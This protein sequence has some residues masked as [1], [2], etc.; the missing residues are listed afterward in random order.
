VQDLDSVLAANGGPSLDDLLSDAD[1][2]ANQP[3]AVTGEQ[4]EPAVISMLDYYRDKQGNLTM[5]KSTRRNVY[6]ALRM[7][8]RWGKRVWEDQ[9]KGVLMLDKE[10]YKDTDDTRI[11]IWLDQVYEL[12]ASTTAV[13]DVTRLIGEENGINPLTEYLDAVS[14]D[15]QERISRWLIDGVG[16]E[17]TTLNRDLG[18]RWLVQAVAR[19]FNPGCKADCVLVLIGPQGVKK[20]TAFRKLAGDEYFADTPMEFGTPNAYSQIRRVWIYE[21]A[22]L[23]SVRRS[24]A[25][26][27]KAFL[28]AQDDTYRPAYGR[29][30]ITVKRHCVFCGTTN[31]QSF[32]NDST[33]SRRFWPVQV[34]AINVDWI[35]ENRDQ[36]WAEAVRAYKNGSRWWLEDGS[37]S[38]LEEASQRFQYRDPWEDHIREWLTRSPNEFTTKDL[39]AGALKLE[40]NHM[41]RGAEMRAAEILHIFGYQR[42]RKRVGN[43]RA[44]VWTT[45][46]DVIAIKPEEPTAIASND[47]VPW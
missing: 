11:A 20:S 25:S 27:T 37:E 28:S 15:S 8:T 6:T 1:D 30:S 31:G 14:W 40:P 10:D 9:F 33:G 5:P 3:N 26:A 16:A 34:G 7:D 44:Y 47:E 32:L 42:T 23:D 38:E 36:L 19:V 2:E 13:A 18:Q 22:E 12:K 29:H 24:A 17:D 43:R 21:V 46:A 41:S 35:E 4:P 39:L 45:E